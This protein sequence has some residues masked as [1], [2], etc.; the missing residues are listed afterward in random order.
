MKQLGNYGSHLELI[1]PEVDG[2]KRGKVG[3]ET[4]ALA[5]QYYYIGV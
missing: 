1:I 2:M 5:V 3:I 4:I